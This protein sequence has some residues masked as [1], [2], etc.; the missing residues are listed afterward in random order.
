ME[1]Q[2]QLQD[3]IYQHLQSGINPDEIT[4]QLR[5]ANWDEASIAQAFTAVQATISPS[6]LPPQPVNAP[7]TAQQPSP[8][9]TNQFQPTGK[10]R[11]RIKTAWLLLK[12]SVKVLRNNRQLL[13]Y[14]FM[15]GILSLLIAII[16]VIIVLAGGDTFVYRATDVFGDEELYF[17]GP[18]MAVA[19]VYYVI[20]SFIIFMYNAGLA[21]HTLDIFRGKSEDYRHYMKLAWSKKGKIFVYSLI[22]ATVGV[23]LRAI[24]QR[25]RWLGYFVSRILGALWT[26]AN[27]F[28]IPIIVETDY[29]AP[30][31][32]KQSTKLF[33][34][35]W[36]ENIA[37]RV[38]FSGI[39]F[40]LYLL[41]IIPLI[42]V[43]GFIAAALG[44]G[45]LILLAVIVLV[46]IILFATIE[47]AASN[48]LSTA[49]YFY[50]RYQ[51]IPAAFDPELLNAAFI[52]KKA[53][54]GL[55]GKN[56]P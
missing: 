22:T 24:E 40:L 38:T 46:S 49:L 48:I 14:P 8:N 9:T 29:S 31:A 13:R 55:F 16:F 35:R 11:G 32:I 6:P 2:K 21:A 25:S 3:Y 54:K 10:K 1:Q 53:R 5:T 30:A 50:A 17:T 37:A 28:T 36:G 56:K 12:Q 20:A 19:F 39:A 47:T 33:L 52:P 43:L 23:I 51:Q 42:F 18:G 4:Q 34:S 41:L 7:D 26:F 27:L 45:G 44:T 15:G